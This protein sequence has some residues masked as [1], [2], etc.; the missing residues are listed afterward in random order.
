MHSL[1]AAECVVAACVFVNILRPFTASV[2]A[3]I[4]RELIV[5]QCMGSF[6]TYLASGG[7]LAQVGA[8]LPKWGDA[9]PSEGMLAQVG[10][11]GRRFRSR[12]ALPTDE[13]I[14]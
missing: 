11:C 6:L 4:M 9:C 5:G 8:C 1:D 10:A 13:A 2:S 7:M 14:E 12:M 3:G